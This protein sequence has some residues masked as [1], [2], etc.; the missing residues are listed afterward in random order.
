MTTV[1]SDSILGTIKLPTLAELIARTPAK[2]QP[3]VTQLGPGALAVAA[4]GLL[5]IEDWIQQAI[6]GDT[7]GACKATISSLLKA[8]FIA[9]WDAD[10]AALDQH[11]ATNAANKAAWQKA[12]VAVL[13]GVLGVAGMLVGL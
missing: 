2:Y 12:A 5:N 4:L 3:L 9:Q 13:T 10:D 11:N 1:P 8:E 6:R 7:V